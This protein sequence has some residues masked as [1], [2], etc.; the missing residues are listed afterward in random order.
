[1]FTIRMT[2]RKLSTTV[3][4]GDADPLRVLTMDE[5]G[6]LLRCTRQHVYTLAKSHGLPLTRLGGRTVVRASELD[7][8]LTAQTDSGA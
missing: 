5:A 1:V 2:S 4:Q 8:W 6:E 3:Q 7:R